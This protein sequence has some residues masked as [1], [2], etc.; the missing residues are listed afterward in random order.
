MSFKTTLTKAYTA[1]ELIKGFYQ[2]GS[3]NCVSIATIKAAIMAFQTR[4]IIEIVHS[5]E[6]GILF[7]MLDNELEYHLLKENLQLVERMANFS[8]KDLDLLPYAYFLFAA[9]A[10]RVEVEGNDGHADITFAEA[11]DTLNDGELF[12]EGPYWLG[13]EEFVIYGPDRKFPANHKAKIFL[14]RQEAGIGKSPKHAW[15]SSNGTN[16]EH[17]IPSRIRATT[18]GAIALDVTAIRGR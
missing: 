18:S 3:G 4:P 5:N 16:D 14:L 8:G 15:F 1:E 9:M 12:T 6:E 17:G 13:L 7:R 2:N 10:K 11:I